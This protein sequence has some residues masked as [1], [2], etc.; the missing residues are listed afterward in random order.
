KPATEQIAV[1]PGEMVAIPFRLD[2]EPGVFGTV[3]SAIRLEGRTLRHAV[4]VRAAARKVELVVLPQ[5]LALGDMTPGEE[6]AV[7]FQV[8]NM[9]ELTAEIHESHVRGELE[10]WLHRQSVKPGTT[11]TL[12]GRVKLNARTVGRQVHAVVA[13]ADQASVVFSA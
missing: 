11:A 4:A 13:L 8:V 7:T 5:T 12:A 6:R 10:I 2:L 3:V 9:G 1:R